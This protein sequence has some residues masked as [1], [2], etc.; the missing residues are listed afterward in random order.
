MNSGDP[1]RN[2]SCTEEE[3][4]ETFDEALLNA[5]SDRKNA[6][7]I[8]WSVANDATF[9]GFTDIAIAA[10]RFMYDICEW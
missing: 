2:S 7:Q 8:A 4:W 6:W 10:T 9:Y 1:Y 3:L 5:F